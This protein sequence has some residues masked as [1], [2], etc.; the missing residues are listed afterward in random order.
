VIREYNNIK[1]SSAL[2]KNSENTSTKKNNTI[3]DNIT[4]KK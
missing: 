2:K 1:N 4:L 3:E